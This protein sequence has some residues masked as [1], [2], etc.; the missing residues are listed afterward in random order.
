MNSKESQGEVWL[1]GRKRAEPQEGAVWNGS[2]GQVLEP[3]TG[4]VCGCVFCYYSKN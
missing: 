3:G 2:P 1:S 4:N